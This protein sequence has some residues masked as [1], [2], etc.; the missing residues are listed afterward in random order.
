[1]R[2]E[3]SPLLCGGFSE[4]GAVKGWIEAMEIAPTILVVDNNEQNL[5][6]VRT[7]L[8]RH[9]YASRL[10]RSGEEALRLIHQEPP[11][12]IILDVMMPGMDGIEVCRRLKDDEGTRLIPVVIMTALDQPEDKVRGIEAGADDFLTKPVNQPELM[13]RVRTALRLKQTIDRKVGLLLHIKE[14]LSKFV[15]LA[16][17]QRIEAAPEPRTWSGGNGTYR[18]CLLM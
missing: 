5:T 17:R 10:A 7:I 2:P 11:E 16:V 15:P 4:Q 13:A 6:L 18:F 14:H 1:L 3:A 9:G 12:L 8:R